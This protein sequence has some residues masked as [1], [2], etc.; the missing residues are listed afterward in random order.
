MTSPDEQRQWFIVHRWQ[1]CDAEIRVAYVRIIAVTAFYAVQLYDFAIRE[2]TSVEFHRT[3]TMMA[4]A[5]IVVSLLALI[6]VRRQYLPP[7]LKYA[8]TMAD[9]V[10][11][12][13]TLLVATG[14]QSP[15]VVG[16]FII[17]ILAAMRFSLPLIRAATV[18]CLVSYLCVLAACHPNWFG[19]EA[20]DFVVPRREELIVGIAIAF[21]GIALGQIARR[22]RGLADHYARRVGADSP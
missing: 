22:V 9:L 8:T 10:L 14:P 19:T 7:W 12:T 4:I 2:A 6:S 15:L 3:M 20:R 17:L 11:L 1:E 18:A 5:W 16:Y 21:A 13:L